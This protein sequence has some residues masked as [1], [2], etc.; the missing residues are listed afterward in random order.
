G[1]LQKPSLTNQLHILLGC[2]PSQIEKLGR[3][4]KFGRNCW[5]IDFGFAGLKT[6]NNIRERLLRLAK[7]NSRKTSN[8]RLFSFK[9]LFKPLILINQAL[10][11][12][13]GPLALTCQFK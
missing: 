7:Q 13:E 11:Q 6:A 10:F 5:P 9:V 4:V 12:F 8:S 3:F 2:T 1:A